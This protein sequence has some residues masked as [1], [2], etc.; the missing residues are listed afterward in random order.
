VIVTLFN[1]LGEEKSS[2]L[3]AAP[4]TILQTPVGVS[5]AV[6]DVR[7]DDGDGLLAWSLA[8]P[9]DID[10]FHV[11]RATAADGDYERLTVAPVVA[12]AGASF[13][14]RDT[15]VI[16]GQDYFYRLEEVRAA[17]PG[18]QHG[19]FAL[20]FETCNALDQNFPNAF[21]PQTTIRFSI[22]REART[23]LTIYDVA[24]RRVRTLIDGVLKPD[25]YRVQ[26]DGAGDHGGPAAS[27][28]YLYKLE[29]DGFS[30]ARKMMLVR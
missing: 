7:A 24:G 5:F 28:V 9:A 13:E 27:G 19:P 20:R 6:I 4:F 3:S 16:A 29:T 30:D 10:G 14:F 21:N 23:R 1:S 18:A 2:G 11:L 8:A 26:W 22:A 25:V 12:G 17:A 15:G